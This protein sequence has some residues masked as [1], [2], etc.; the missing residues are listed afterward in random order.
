MGTPHEP[1]GLPRLDGPFVIDEVDAERT[2][3]IP[4][5]A[6]RHEGSV[7]SFLLPTKS[8]GRHVVDWDI[9]SHSVAHVPHDVGSLRFS[10]VIGTTIYCANPDCWTAR[11][12]Q[13]GRG[14]ARV[15]RLL[16]LEL[17]P[18]E[19]IV[20]RYVAFAGAKSRTDLTTKLR[21]DAG[22]RL[23]LEC[24]AC[25]Q[26]GTLTPVLTEEAPLS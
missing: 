25:G 13:S 17:E 1:R 21:T 7:V 9:P 2:R 4:I 12:R 6:T 26:L 23:D 5:L 22:L 8:G 11:G 18:P 24:H 20:V 15:A 16:V 10:D 3:L 19:W 14:P